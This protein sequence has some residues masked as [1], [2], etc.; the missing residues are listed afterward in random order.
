MESYPFL[1]ADFERCKQLVAPF[2]HR[3][4]VLHSSQIDNLAGAEIFFKCENFQKT[5]AFKVRGAAN[6]ISQLP[7][8]KLICAHSSGKHAQAVA[9]VGKKLGID[10]RIIMPND[11][12]LVK[13]E[14]VKGYGAI[15]H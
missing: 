9:Y 3:T 13:K 14:A 4:P 1:S 10:V 15:V 12:P 7:P 2:V 11:T 6:K 8:L 5:G